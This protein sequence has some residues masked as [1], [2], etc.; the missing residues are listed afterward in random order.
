MSV[1][2]AGPALGQHAGDVIREVEQSP[3]L[4]DWLLKAEP[5]VRFVCIDRSLRSA[6]GY[7]CGAE[8]GGMAPR[9]TLQD[10]F[11]PL[12]AKGQ[13]V[14]GYRYC[15]A[16]KN[17]VG[18]TQL[19]S[20]DETKK[21][22][23]LAQPARFAL[24]LTCSAVYTANQYHIEG[25]YEAAVALRRVLFCASGLTDS[26]TFMVES[27]GL[28][29]VS[30]HLLGKVYS[31]CRSI[32]DCDVCFE[33]Q[34]NCTCD[35]AL[36][37]QVFAPNGLPRLNQWADFHSLL[38]SAGTRTRPAVLDMR[39][40]PQGVYAQ[41]RVQAKAA[42]WNSDCPDAFFMRSQFAKTMNPRASHPSA[43]SNLLDLPSSRAMEEFRSSISIGFKFGLSKHLQDFRD[44]GQWSIEDGQAHDPSQVK[45]SIVPGWGTELVENNN[46]SS[47]QS[48]PSDGDTRLPGATKH[49]FDIVN[50]KQEEVLEKRHTC[51]VCGVQFAR[52]GHL[53]QHYRCVHE[54]KRPFQCTDCGKN[55]TMKNNLSRHVRTVHR[56]VRLA[57]CPICDRKF[58]ELSDAKR[59]MQ[60]IHSVTNATPTVL[61]SP[62]RPRP[63]GTT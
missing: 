37:T 4:S 53:N 45:H 17:F 34:L 55:F 40:G 6:L 7:S 23:R 25:G 49:S 31:S 28:D 22:L 42:H 14:L 46:S 20:R 50:L 5:A 18:T 57:A 60:D 8:L 35:D 33:K 13:F 48:D 27:R 56:N 44:P 36:K 41:F 38:G 24:D 30:N 61:R 26:I 19:G 54:N 63:T 52:K 32:R 15:P 39:D 12:F 47:L 2:L 9:V 21:E 58:K 16:F 51:P 43:D 3:V 1:V 62:S 11:V 10:L 59:H 29:I